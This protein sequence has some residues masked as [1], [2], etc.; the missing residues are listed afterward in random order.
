MNCMKCGAPL[1]EDSKFCTACGAPLE[2]PESAAQESET[3]PVPDRMPLAPAQ[4]KL[5]VSALVGLVVGSVLMIIGFVILGGAGSTVSSTSFGGDFYTY[6]YRG[7][8]AITE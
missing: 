5:P 2:L 8:V 1:D 4:K 6:T 7:I 3:M